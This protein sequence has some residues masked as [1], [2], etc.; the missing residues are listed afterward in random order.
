MKVKLTKDDI[1]LISKALIRLRW[2]IEKS[3]GQNAEFQKC[4]SLADRLAC[5]HDG[6]EL[7]FLLPPKT[8]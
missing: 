4:A 2:D 6:G 7:N 3:E 5:N 1:E 8:D